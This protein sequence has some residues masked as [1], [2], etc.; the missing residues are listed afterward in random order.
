MP[1]AGF[2]HPFEPDANYHRRLD[3]YTT[4]RHGA[5]AAEKRFRSVLGYP[6]M[7]LLDATTKAGGAQRL[8]N[9]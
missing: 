6:S 4:G 3:K 8:G 5:T 7:G 9:P 2:V 1:F